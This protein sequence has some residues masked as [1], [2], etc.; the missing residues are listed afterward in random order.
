MRRT[1]TI[2]FLAAAA[3]SAAVA[4]FVVF[5][6]PPAALVLD[7][8]IPDTVA[9]G[10]YHV[11]SSRSD[12]TGTVEEIAR[13]AAGAGLRFVVFTDHGDGTAP[14]RP[15]AYIDGVLCLDAVEINTQ[16]GHLVALNLPGA[17]PYPLAGGAR[18][19]I[20]DLR[21][22]GATAIAAHPDSPASS[23]RWR[24]AARYDGLEWINADAEWRDNS[25]RELLAATARSLVHAPESIATLFERPDFTLQ[26]WDAALRTR[27]VIGLAALDAHARLG[28]DDEELH[29][30]AIAW[31]SYATLF[32]TLAQ[33]VVLDAP[34]SGR[35]GDDARAV[36]DAL[37]GGRAFSVIT[38]LA[39]PAVLDF[40]LE[41]GSAR[42]GMGQDL[43][44]WDPAAPTRLVA[45]VPQAPGARLAVTLGGRIV[46]EGRGGLDLVRPFPPGAYRVEA[47]LPGSTLPWIV[48]NPIYLGMPDDEP[49]DDDTV[50]A[51]PGAGDLVLAPDGEWTLERD[52]RSTA[53][54][55]PE[56]P[57]IRF[58]YALAGGRPA[59]QYAALVAHPPAGAGL[60]R[61]AFTA[62]ASR[63]MRLSVQ[64]RLPGADAERWR[65]SIYLDET[66]R[67]VV[68]RLADMERASGLASSL[69]PIVARV[70]S[71]LFVV[72]T[73]NTAPGTAG[74]IW[75]RDVRLG[76]P[77]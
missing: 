21:R 52:D 11:H 57:V 74:T 14:P 69:R 42:A 49:D 66:A 29:A 16:N 72:D 28:A 5:T 70:Q 13:A 53:A 25:A 4:F 2:V 24:G 12:G 7:G 43:A 3:L 34:L 73:L 9:F 44:P 30:M 46:A 54:M 67:D 23:L 64:V 17:A 77:Q 31:P 19:V 59:G 26:R 37:T 10:A 50:D 60:D 63:P 71:L 20:A 76:V 48:S 56:P 8:P 62:R 27:R 22:L 1:L 35:A 55:T 6:A 40:A 61:V 18:D 32:R 68:V 51:A 47:F 33:A 75:L 39:A 38:A 15:P 41:Q 45:A 58:D 65:R 36:L